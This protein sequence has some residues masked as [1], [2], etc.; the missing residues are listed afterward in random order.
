[1]PITTSCFLQAI[2]PVNVKRRPQKSEIFTST[3]YKNKI[4]QNREVLFDKR[5][6]IHKQ[7]SKSAIQKCARKLSMSRSM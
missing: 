3:P 5:K 2:P 4:E 1:M 6:H 7:K